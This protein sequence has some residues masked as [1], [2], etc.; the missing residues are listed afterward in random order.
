MIF[1]LSTDLSV[2]EVEQRWQQ[3]EQAKNERLTRE[4]KAQSKAEAQKKQRR[5]A[6]LSLLAKNLTA[7]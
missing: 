4:A 1:E 3:A 2:P 5:E 7:A 6:W